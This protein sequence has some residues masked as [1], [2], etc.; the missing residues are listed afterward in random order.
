MVGKTGNGLTH[1]NPGFRTTCRRSHWCGKKSDFLLLGCGRISVSLLLADHEHGIA[2]G[3]GIIDVLTLKFARGSVEVPDFPERFFGGV[4]S[5][6]QCNR[7]DENDRGRLA[8]FFGCYHFGCV[9]TVPR[10]RGSSVQAPISWRLES[11]R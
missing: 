3:V 7:H 4:R 11:S 8:Y 10:R 2:L 6:S 9:I 1:R 5:C